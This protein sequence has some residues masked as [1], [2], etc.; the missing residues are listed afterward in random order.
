MQRRRFLEY[1]G[2]LSA[3]LGFASPMLASETLS[4]YNEAIADERTRVLTKERNL[5]VVLDGEDWLVSIDSN[6]I[7][8]EQKWYLDAR[9]DAK[10]APVPSIIQETFPAF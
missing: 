7:G 6:N 4:S 2:R 10:K 9:S 8:R 1:A 5:A 3:G